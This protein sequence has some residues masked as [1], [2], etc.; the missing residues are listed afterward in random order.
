MF[1]DSNLAKSNQ[2][3]GIL[4]LIKAT[5][6][7]LIFLLSAELMAQT[8]FLKVD[9][10]FKINEL[11]KLTKD[12]Y[13]IT[14]QVEPGYYLYQKRFWLKDEESNKLNFSIRSKGVTKDDPNFGKVTVHYDAAKIQF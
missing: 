6:V 7:F 5:W 2:T 4:K 12:T 11:S 1:L 9:D 10:A 3:N 8:S 14:W 13:Q